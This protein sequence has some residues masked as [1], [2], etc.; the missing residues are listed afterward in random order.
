M[1]EVRAPIQAQP[2]PP[3]SDTASALETLPEVAENVEPA[4]VV[5]FMALVPEVACTDAAPTLAIPQLQTVVKIAE[6]I[7]IWMVP[8][9][10]VEIPELKTVEKIREVPAVRM[11]PQALP[12]D[13]ELVHPSPLTMQVAK[14]L[15][16]NCLRKRRSLP[17]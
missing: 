8:E 6:I 13:V 1:V 9:M 14:E 3:L 2:A 11:G 10:T 17:A 12:V 16:P 5:E 7:E 4:P 15:E